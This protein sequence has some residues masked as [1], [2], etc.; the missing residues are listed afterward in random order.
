MKVLGAIIFTLSLAPAMEGEKKAHP[1]EPI[2]IVIEKYNSTSGM[3]ANVK[4]KV[5]LALLEETRESKGQLFFEKGKFRLELSEPDKS[6]MVVGHGLIWI[7]AEMEG[8]KGKTKHVTKIRSLSL[9][10][11]CARHWQLC[12]GAS[13]HGKSLKFL[14]KRKENLLLNSY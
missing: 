9:A 1:T 10:R 3:K 14:R 11:Q 7:G 6:T 4:K 13:A 12:L 8:F 2:Q 5:H